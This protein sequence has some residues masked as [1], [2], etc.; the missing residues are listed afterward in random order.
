MGI[1]ANDQKQNTIDNVPMILRT[2]CP[3]GRLVLSKAKP[4][5]C[6]AMTTSKGKRAMPFLKNMI[7]ATECPISA[8]NLIKTFMQLNKVAARAAAAKIFKG[9]LTGVSV[10][11][12]LVMM[13]DR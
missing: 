9:A 12:V 4:C 5:L 1:R 7:W 8:D 3:T 2:A 10:T 11:E 6:V 13:M